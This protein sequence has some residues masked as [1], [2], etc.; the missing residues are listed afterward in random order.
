MVVVQ[1]E[2]LGQQVFGPRDWQQWILTFLALLCEAAARKSR[3]QVPL[4]VR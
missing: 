4:L 3:C 1:R 2:N